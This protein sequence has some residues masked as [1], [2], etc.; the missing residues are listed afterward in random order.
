MRAHEGEK[1]G[2]RHRL[3]IQPERGDVCSTAVRYGVERA[4][5]PRGQPRHAPETDANRMMDKR[6]HLRYSA[7]FSGTPRPFTA[8]KTC[9]LSAPVTCS[10]PSAPL[11]NARKIE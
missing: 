5:R 7:V 10:M 2:A 8:A 9:A 1:L 11:L 4:I 3:A 6:Q